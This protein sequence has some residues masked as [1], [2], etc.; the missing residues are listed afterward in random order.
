MHLLRWHAIREA[1]AAQDAVDRPRRRGRA[2][3]AQ[4]R[5]G[6]PT[7][8]L[9]ELEASFGAEW[10]DSA[11]AHEIVLRP[12]VYPPGWSRAGSPSDPGS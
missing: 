11:P 1:L 4:A 5:K 2:R 7:Y 9:W 6:E 10:V 12:L 3:G 8:G